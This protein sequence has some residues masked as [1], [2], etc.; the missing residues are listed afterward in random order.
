MLIDDVMLFDAGGHALDPGD[1]H[2]FLG[3]RCAGGL[4]GWYGPLPERLAVFAARLAA[5]LRGQPLTVDR[6]PALLADVAPTGT[7]RGVRAAL[8]AVDCAAWDALGRAAGVPVARLIAAEPAARVPAYASW[9]SLDVT[10]ERGRDQVTR[11]AG[12][13]WTHTKWSAR[14]GAGCGVGEM[15]DHIAAVTRAAGAPVAIDA[16][17]TWTSAVLDAVLAA[18]PAGVVWLEDPFPSGHEPL[19]AGLPVA[20]GEHCTT[21]EDLLDLAQ[22]HRPAVLTPDV[23]WLGGLSAARRAL[24][25]LA[26]AEVPVW[27][28]GRAFAPALHLAAAIPWLIA[29]MEYQHHWWPRRMAVLAEE[30][31]VAAGHVLVPDRPGLGLA[32]KGAF[33]A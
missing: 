10:T 25:A 11:L 4:T 17:G 28:H 12:Q 27:L 29:G 14:V 18:P 22:R 6:L 21:T 31:P 1:D 15:A 19:P 13:P 2:Y 5:G 30:F 8:G 33:R 32:P 7:G 3:L 26:S 9:L 24:L 20:L 23:L 16:V